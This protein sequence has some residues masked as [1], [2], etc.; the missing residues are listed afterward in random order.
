MPQKKYK[1][2]YL[3]A[4]DRDLA[5]IFTYIAVDL[6]A[7]QAAVNLLEKIDQAVKSLDT[8]PYAHSVYQSAG[9]DTAPFE[10]RALVVAS[11]LVFYYVNEN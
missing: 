4:A 3:P 2:E 11:Y 1:I 6:A 5:E 9:L 7:P 10:F 8:F